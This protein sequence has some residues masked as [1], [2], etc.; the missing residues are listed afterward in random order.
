MEAKPVF[1]VVNRN[2]LI[3]RLELKI[4]DTKFFNILLKMFKANSIFLLDILN[5][6]SEVLQE[7]VLSPILT[8]IYF[9]ELDLFV[10]KSILERYR[11][12]VKPLIYSTFLRSKSFVDLQSF[13]NLKQ[14]KEACNISF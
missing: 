14:R 3:A 10:K 7:H 5:S 12:G 8:N 2:I 1:G 4:K 9:H 13:S 6:K 11:K